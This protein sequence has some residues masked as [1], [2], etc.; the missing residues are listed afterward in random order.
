MLALCLLL[1]SAFGVS[2]ILLPTSKMALLYNIDERLEPMGWRLE[3]C[4]GARLVGGSDSG[5]GRRA[6]CKG[7]SFEIEH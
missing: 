4:R 2:P 1:G 5:S 6:N 7:E 3:G